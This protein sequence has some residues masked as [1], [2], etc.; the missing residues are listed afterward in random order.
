MI[1]FDFL[2]EIKQSSCWISI[3]EN[4]SLYGINFQVIRICVVGWVSESGDRHGG[5]WCA[6]KC[7]DVLNVRGLQWW[8]N[9][10]KGFVSITNYRNGYDTFLNDVSYLIF[11]LQAPK[12]ISCLPN[13]FRP[14]VLVIA[15]QQFHLDCKERL[16][17]KPTY[18]D[19]FP[20]KYQ[21]NIAVDLLYTYLGF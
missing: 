6:F 21:S 14:F 3:A 17:S 18:I 10:S 2:F 7:E 11:I 15:I 1:S 20:F 16:L 12:G 8:L 4:K 5:S 9:Q 19:F 13:K